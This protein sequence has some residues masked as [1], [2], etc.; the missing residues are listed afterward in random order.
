MTI[1]HGL[2]GAVLIFS[3]LLSAGSVL[4][5]TPADSDAAATNKN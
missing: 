1:R 5:Q 4:A 3:A 2:A